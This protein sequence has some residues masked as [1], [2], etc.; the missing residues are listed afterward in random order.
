MKPKEKKT[1]QNSWSLERSVVLLPP[2]IPEHIIAADT[3]KTAQC[4]SFGHNRGS[5]P[6]WVFDWVMHKTL[7][8][9][10]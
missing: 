6:H 2:A 1:L 4:P 9:V 7:E 10:P 3:V 5:L 8:S